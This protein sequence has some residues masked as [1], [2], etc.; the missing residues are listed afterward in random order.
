VCNLNFDRSDNLYIGDAV[1]NLV[2]KVTASTGI[3]TTIAGLFSYSGG[4]NG[5]NIAATSAL[6]NYPHDVVIDSHFNIYICDRSNGRI[7]KVD[8]ST[9]IITTVAGGGSG[10]DDGFATAASLAS[11]CFSTFDS[12]GNLYIS[13][14]GAYKIR[15][16]TNLLDNLPS[17]KPT[18]YPTL[19]PTVRNS[20]ISTFAGT[21]SAGYSGD[22]GDAT[23]ATVHKP[24]GILC[25]SSGDIYFSDS[26]NNRIRKISFSTGIITTFVGT[27]AGEYSGDDGLATSAAIYIPYGLT[28]DASGKEQ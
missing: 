27:G 4:Y 26:L 2:R 28:Q 12:A 14:C 3:I 19:S 11:P 1:E 25:H 23:S 13:E 21:G 18:Y 7:R 6:L 10:G 8:A 16:V 15:K 24:T 5:D 20:I 9:N 17:V 22:G